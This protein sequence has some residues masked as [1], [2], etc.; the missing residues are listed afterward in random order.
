MPPYRVQAPPAANSTLPFRLCMFAAGAVARAP[1]AAA[2]PPV[3]Y[4]HRS[5]HMHN[6]VPTPAADSMAVTACIIPRQICNR[7]LCSAAGRQ[8]VRQQGRARHAT[9]RRWVL[10]HACSR[11]S[12]HASRLHPLALRPCKWC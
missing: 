4:L 9:G 3:W 10:G 12:A 2:A 1:A 11:A 7:E 5:P 8:G 6:L